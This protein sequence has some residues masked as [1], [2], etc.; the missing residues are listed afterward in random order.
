MMSVDINQWRAAIGCFRVFT[1]R[2]ESFC[3][4]LNFFVVLLQVLRLYQ[5][6]ACFILISIVTLPFTAAVHFFIGHY[7]YAQ[8]CYL[9]LFSRT[10]SY[11]RLISYVLF[12]LLK[13]IPFALN[14]LFRSKRSTTNYLFLVYV[15]SYAVCIAFNLLYSQWVISTFILLSGDVELNPGPETLK[16]CCWNLN[17]ISAHDF[18]R[19]SLIEAYNSIYNYDLIGIAETHLDDSVDQERLILKGYEF[20]NCNHPLNSKRGGV[21]LYVKDSLPKKERPD[22]ATLPESIVCE[23]NLDRKKYFFVVVYR[24]PSQDQQ[25][26]DNFMNNFELMLS[27][28]SAE[29]PYAVI[30][31][32]DFNC[33]SPQWWEQ[34]NENEEGRQFEP[35]TTDLGLHQLISGPTHMIGESKSCIDLIFTDE[36]N[37]FIESGIHPPPPRHEQCHHQIIH[38]KLSVRN[39]APPPYTRK[40][41]FYDRGN[42]PAIRKSVEM[43]RWQE[44]F[45]EVPHPDEQVKILNEVLL[46]ICSNFI[47][48]KL[49]KIRAHQVHWITPNI[50][51]FLR[52]KNRAFKSFVKKGQPE[53]MLEGIQNM[54]AQGSKLVEDAKNKYFTNVGCTLSDPSTGTKKYWYLI[55]KIFNKAKIPEIPPLL[56]NDIFVLAFSSKAQIFNDYSILQCTTLD[57]GSEIPSDVPVIGSQLQEFVISEEKILRIIRNLNPNKAHG[58]D[59]ISVR[60]IKMC[61]NLLIIPLILIFQNCLRHGIFP[62]TWKRANVVPVHKKNEK[63]LKENYR[64]I[65]LLPIFSKI[66]EKLI[67][68]SLYSHLERENLLNPNQSGFRPGDSTMNQ[69]LSIT[70]LATSLSRGKNGRRNKSER[71]L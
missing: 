47:P 1:T 52:K 49:K 22:I 54:I 29:E 53:D 23:L 64:P 48:N 39:L 56:E 25:E 67:Y 32:G 50:K 36:P 55:N 37:L 66:L 31:T 70:G 71:G 65:S 6:A 14:S 43:F 46:N 62:E 8:S 18:L 58:W 63:N 35:L 20:I 19:V 3:C 69:L 5:F 12:E 33:R 17:S 68:E 38:G 51:S 59:E 57:T 41:W 24:S 60:M 2:S 4:V 34:D 10:Y 40:L 30:I 7:I 9:P 21:G 28:M 44:T 13:R 27:K 45:E 15:Q 26:F 11:I 16:F 61:D 42:I